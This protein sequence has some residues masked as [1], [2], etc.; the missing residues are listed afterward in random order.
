MDLALS[1]AK[2]RDI[3]SSQF[4]FDPGDLDYIRT[5]YIYLDHDQTVTASAGGSYAFG[6]SRV[7]ADLLHGSGLRRSGTVPNGDKVPDYTQVNLGAAHDF[8]GLPG[9]TLTLR[10]DVI[11]VFDQ[12]YEIRDGTG[13]GV[14]QPQF[15]PRRGFYVGLSKAF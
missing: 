12:V 3:I 9:G 6:D 14:G 10:A 7:S 5:H 8:T 4:N 13:V 1:Q 15:G 2:G 11:N